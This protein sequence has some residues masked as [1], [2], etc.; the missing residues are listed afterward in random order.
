MPFLNGRCRA[1]GRGRGGQGCA[2]SKEALNQ[3][4]VWR[5]PLIH[6]FLALPLCF[7]SFSR[8]FFPW[9]AANTQGSNVEHR[10]CSSRSS[11]MKPKRKNL[12]LPELNATQRT[13]R[14]RP[15]FSEPDSPEMALKF[16]FWFP[17][18]SQWYPRG[19]HTSHRS[20]AP[21]RRPRPQPRR[22]WPRPRRGLCCGGRAWSCRRRASSAPGA[23]AWRL[24]GLGQAWAE[25]VL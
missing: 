21:R 5:S 20:D 22:R 19:P 1:V 17:F 14:A 11:Q 16:S 8:S 12:R 23:R 15:F 25:N 13:N 7:L 4:I 10:A 9:S 2:G 6:G 18:K 3:G 24:R